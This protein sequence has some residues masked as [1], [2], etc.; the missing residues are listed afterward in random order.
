MHLTEL[1]F[2]LCHI[3]VSSLEAMLST[4]GASSYDFA[5]VDAAKTEYDA[6]YELCL[7]LVR[8]GVS[9]RRTVV[10]VYSVLIRIHGRFT[11]PN[12]CVSYTTRL[13]AVE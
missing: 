8:P 3:V 12:P 9:T 2:S 6:Y 7:Q 1:W 5:Y 13:L 11:T 10:Q 4:G